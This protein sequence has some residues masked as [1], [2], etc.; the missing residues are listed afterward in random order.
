[1]FN[2]VYIVTGASSGIGAKTVEL[3]NEHGA[4]VVAIARNENRLNE[5]KNKCKQPENVFVEVKDLT[6]DIDNLAK[7]VKELKDKYG[8]FKGLVIVPE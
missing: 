6:D 1:M 3:L 8:K 4:V 2:G 5:I 7:Y